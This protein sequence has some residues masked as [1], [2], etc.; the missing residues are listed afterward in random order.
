MAD[1]ARFTIR[2]RKVE[3]LARYVF[4]SL[5]DAA[6][7]LVA[8]FGGTVVLSVALH[9][10][11]A[12]M[13]EVGESRWGIKY[14]YFVA[15]G[16]A[17]HET[18]HALGCLFMYPVGARIMEYAPFSPRPDGVLGWVN[19][20]FVGRPRTWITSIVR[21]VVG[22]GPIWFG[23]FVVYLL[24]A[25]F[26]SMPEWNMATEGDVVGFV[27]GVFEGAFMFLGHVLS[28]MVE[29]PFLSPIY[30]YLVFCV[31]SEM[32][33]SPADMQGM[34]QGTLCFLVFFVL[35]NM[36]PVVDVLVGSV[37]NVLSAYM[38]G[39]NAIMLAVLILNAL[40]TSVLSVALSSD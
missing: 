10:A 5:V 36:I 27:V 11:S 17:C 3:A 9:H 39:V 13:R 18:G 16:V 22:T 7:S 20:S 33:L 28:G 23:C 38:I 6:V 12:R 29:Q 24:T 4:S 25:L 37:V 8:L 30:I 15:V 19:Y 2:L 14:F 32:K 1:K 34:W 35:L 26:Y 40:L 21:V 31:V